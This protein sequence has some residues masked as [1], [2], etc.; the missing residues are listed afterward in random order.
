MAFSSRS[1]R[2]ISEKTTLCT[3]PASPDGVYF[4]MKGKGSSGSNPKPCFFTYFTGLSKGPNKLMLFLSTLPTVHF[5]II[6]GF[7]ISLKAQ[8]G[9]L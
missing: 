1:G 8:P 6:F 2:H 3:R 7:G 4:R 9:W 5:H